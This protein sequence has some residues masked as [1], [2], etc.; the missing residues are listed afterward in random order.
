MKPDTPFPSP[1]SLNAPTA[2]PL[3]SRRQWLRM[4]GGTGLS[5]AG[6]AMV[7]DVRLFAQQV[8]EFIEGPPVPDVAP[9]QLSPHVWMVYAKDGFPT[10]ENQGLMA[11][12]LFVIT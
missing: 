8:Q 9:E 4:V 7:P 2:V 3:R 12:V 10:A 6:L 1:P 5:V 11:S